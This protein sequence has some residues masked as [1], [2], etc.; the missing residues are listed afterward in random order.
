MQRTDTKTVSE[1]IRRLLDESHEQEQPGGPPT[2]TE[3]GKGAG[4]G[5]DRFS[6]I[7]GQQIFYVRVTERCDA[8]KPGTNIRCTRSQHDGL[9]HIG[10]TGLGA[11]VTWP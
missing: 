1:V 4:K 5:E 7:V 8:L 2:F 11:D 3:E 6:L 9:N 10:V